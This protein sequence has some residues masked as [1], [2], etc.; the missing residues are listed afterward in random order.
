M[1]SRIPNREMTV[2]SRGGGVS[3]QIRPRTALLILGLSAAVII[4]IIFGTGWGEQYISP[5]GVW[6]TIWGTG[7]GEYDFIVMTLRL[8]RVLVSLLAGAALGVSGAVLQGVIRNPLASPDII[9]ITGGASAAAVGF[10]AFLGG[11]VSI[12]LLPLAAILGA[13]AVS[14]LVY[15]LSW[16]KGVSPVRLVL[17]GTGLSAAASAATTLMLVL[18]SDTTAGQAYIWMTGS[19]YGSTWDDVATLLPAVVIG[20]PLAAL[21]ARSLNAQELGDDTA[22]GL[23]VAVQPHRLVLLL[24]SVVLAG[25]AVSVAGALGFV[26]LIAPHAAR[27]WA[28]RPFGALTAVS[29]LCGALLVFL[30]DLIARTVF[31]PLDVPAGVFTAGVGAP[32]FIYLLFHNRNRL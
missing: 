32:F 2:R 15:A 22:G 26:G 12:K 1:N 18:S 3:F 7:Q 27:K 11:T 8:P 9:G 29:A 20:I 31:Y 6:Q 28:G 21:F 4:A 5:L 24:I 17:I 23:G 19:V 14:L 10:L 30:A 25:F 16:N 13:L